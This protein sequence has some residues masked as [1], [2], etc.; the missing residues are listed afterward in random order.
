MRR[1]AAVTVDL[2]DT[3]VQEHPGGSQKV[4]S[5]RIAK[6]GALLESSGIVHTE[7]EF[8]RAYAGTGDFLEMTW[9]KMRDV[10]SK[11]QVLFMLSCL[12]D[13]LAGKLEKHV[14]EDLE[15][16]YSEGILTNPPRLLPG[17]KEGL[18]DLK[19]RG[20]KLGL[21][22]N[23]GR[24]PGAILRRVM[25][26]MGIGEVFEV[27]TFSNETLVRKPA[28]SAF[29]VT[30]ERLRASPRACV[31]VGDDPE[32]DIAGARAAGLHAIQILRRGIAESPL[33]D[34]HASTLPE[35]VERIARL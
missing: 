23:T 24:T 30:Y 2:W 10:T 3:L 16:A 27:M 34:D 5:A 15:S 17:A 20:Y 9:S 6:M 11:D 35:A 4:A 28:E 1:I 31:H 33:A 7:E 18:Y 13:K 8:K 12:D 19:E 26:E 29:R 14:L 21:I 25:G 22:S 32:A